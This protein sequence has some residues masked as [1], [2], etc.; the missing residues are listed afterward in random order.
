MPAGP[1]AALEVIEPE[2]VLQ[3]PELLLDPPATF[4][5]GHE[6][7]EAQGLAAEV[8]HPVLGRGGP[9]GRPRPPPAGRW[10]PSGSAPG[11]HRDTGQSAPGADPALPRRRSAEP[12]HPRGAGGEPAPGRRAVPPATTPGTPTMRGERRPSSSCCFLAL[13]GIGTPWDARLALPLTRPRWMSQ[14]LCSPPVEAPSRQVREEG[15]QGRRPHSAFQPD[16]CSESR[17][18]KTWR[19]SKKT[20][21]E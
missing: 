1:G 12:G 21:W 17:I 15:L 16:A 11:G 5:Q 20:S 9:S 13:L 2:F 7:A 19:D 14:G 10:P 18:Q 4:R 6:P 3:L 8:G